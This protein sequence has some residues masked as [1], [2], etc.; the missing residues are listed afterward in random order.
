MTPSILQT[1][2]PGDAPLRAG[3]SFSRRAALIGGAAVLVA[4]TALATTLVMRPA[5]HEAAPQAE[6]A[7]TM[8]AATAQAPTSPQKSSGLVG[9][10]VAATAKPA[11]VAGEHVAK[12]AAPNSANVSTPA[13]H[14][15]VAACTTCG[16]VEAVTPIQQ[17]GDATGVGAV[18][19]ALVGGLLGH[20][21]GGGTG[22][23]AMT[24]VGVVGGGIA[25][26]EIEKRARGKTAYQVKVRMDDGSLRTITQSTAPAVGQKVTVDGQK[27]TARA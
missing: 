16:V 27:L 26:H 14:A 12:A 24:A 25:G 6:A 18:G 7:S 1:S 17:K 9:G 11:P 8:P 5:S 15:T 23:D 2:T 3:P 13:A 20:Q 10:P 4:A 21:L 22:R 19:G